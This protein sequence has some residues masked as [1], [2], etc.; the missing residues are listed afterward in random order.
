M[1]LLQTF[2]DV[3][4]VRLAAERATP[5]L[6]RQQAMQDELVKK[7]KGK[8]IWTDQLPDLYNPYSFRSLS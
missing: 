3:E 8:L 4:R 1:I 5:N 7:S 2:G 6:E